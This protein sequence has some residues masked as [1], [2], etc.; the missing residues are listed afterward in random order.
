MKTIK[1]S[2]FYNPSIGADFCFGQDCKA[3]VIYEEYPSRTPVLR[4]C[5]AQ[6]RILTQ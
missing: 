1:K 6:V 5:C 2:S 3:F 4:S